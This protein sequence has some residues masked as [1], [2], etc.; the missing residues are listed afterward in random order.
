MV[1]LYERFL[2]DIM[3]SCLVMDEVGHIAVQ[4]CLV[5]LHQGSIRVN[6]A[7]N[8]EGDDCFIRLVEVVWHLV[9]VSG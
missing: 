2:Y 4:L 6:L 8:D 7:A 9:S 1:Y 3:R 5:P